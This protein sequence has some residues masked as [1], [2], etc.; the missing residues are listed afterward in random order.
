[1]ERRDGIFPSGPVLGGQRAIIGHNPSRFKNFAAN[2]LRGVIE[3]ARWHRDFHSPALRYVGR[4][5]KWN[6]SKSRNRSFWLFSKRTET[7]TTKF[8]L[9]RRR[10]FVRQL[11]RN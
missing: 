1:M 8:F 2:F 5:S 3:R 7:L 6:E 10:D 11:S 4:F 9:R